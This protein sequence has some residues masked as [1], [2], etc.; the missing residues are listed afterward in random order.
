[1]AVSVAFIDKDRDIAILKIVDSAFKA[2][3]SLPYS[4]RRKSAAIAEPIFTLGYPRNDI[5]Y[6]EGYVAART[7]FNGDTLTCQ[8]AIAANPG[9]SGG[10]ILNRNGEV[11]GVLSARQTSAE[12]VVFATQSKYIFNVLAQLQK[13]DVNYQSIKVSTSSALKGMDRMEQVEKIR[14]YIYMVKVN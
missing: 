14:D 7:G 11:V 4:I 5:V 10:P 3:T 1:L 6:G 9:N 8:I 2:S 13:S 12:G